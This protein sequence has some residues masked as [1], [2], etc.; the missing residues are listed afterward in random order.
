MIS[1]GSICQASCFFTKVIT[2]G[3]RA[4]NAFLKKGT[5]E[6]M[7]SGGKNEVVVVLSSLSE[8]IG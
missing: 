4:V 1:G 2:L 6:E 3:F 8:P 5:G 7:L